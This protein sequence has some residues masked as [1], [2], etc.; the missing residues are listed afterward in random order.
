MPV[1]FERTNLS[2]RSGDTVTQAVTVSDGTSALSWTFSVTR[3]TA[4]DPIGTA[5]VE[6]Q[7]ADGSW[8]TRSAFV[9]SGVD[10]TSPTVTTTGQLPVRGSAYRLRGSFASRFRVNLRVETA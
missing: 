2:V 9:V 5:W 6:E 1:L 10:P 8:L 7:Q 4:D 3:S